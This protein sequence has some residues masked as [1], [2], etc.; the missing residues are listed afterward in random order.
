MHG[1]EMCTATESPAL[2]L[3]SMSDATP[4]C[5]PRR[6][7]SG[8]SQA[9]RRRSPRAGSRSARRSRSHSCT[10][11]LSV[12]QHHLYRGAS[13][14]TCLRR[15]ERPGLDDHVQHAIGVTLMADGRKRLRAMFSTS[16]RPAS[17][18]F[19]S[20]FLVKTM[21]SRCIGQREVRLGVRDH[22]HSIAH[23]AQVVEHA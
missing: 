11:R 19:W 13:F 5:R 18:C 20:P 23:V 10:S 9:A 3:V 14:A 21:S 22:V 4:Y 7:D 2:S 16:R 6:R 12:S 17:C 15:S 8:R 1:S